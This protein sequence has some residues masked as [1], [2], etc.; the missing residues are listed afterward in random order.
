MGNYNVI[1]TCRNSEKIIEPSLTSIIEQSIKPKYIIIVDD[2]SSDS[3]PNIL[4]HIQ[5]GKTI[6]Q[7]SS[8]ISLHHFPNILSRYYDIASF[9]SSLL[10]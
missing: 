4:K 6:S 1:L 7:V 2:G 9:C 5:K 3:T 10:V 8:S